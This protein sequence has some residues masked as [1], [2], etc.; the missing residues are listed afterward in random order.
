MA[1]GVG[2]F[3]GIYEIFKSLKT[4]EAKFQDMCWIFS[5]LVG[6]LVQSFV[7]DTLHW[8]HFWIILG[9]VFGIAKLKNKL[10]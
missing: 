10:N 9:F 5:S 4:D 1:L 6:I 2:V 3:A 8:R 7:I